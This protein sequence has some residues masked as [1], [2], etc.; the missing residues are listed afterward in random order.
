MPMPPRPSL[1]V[2]TGSRG[3]TGGFV[4]ALREAQLLADIAD[5]TL[6]VPQDSQFDDTATGGIRLLKLPFAQPRP[7]IGSVLGYPFRL[8]HAGWRLRRSMMVAGCK[9]LQINDF[10]FMEGAVARLFG[11]RGRIVTWVR[12]DPRRFGRIGALWLWLD[13]H[14]S[15][16][17]VAVSRHIQDAMPAKY[18]TRLIYDPSVERAASRRNPSAATILFPGNYTAGK[19]QDVAL[20]AFARL[21]QKFP[22]AKLVF[23]G[24]E[25]GLPKHAHYRE[26]LKSLAA[27]LGIA[28][29]VTFGD[30]LDDLA[31]QYASATVVLN[32]S[33]SE[34]FSLICQEAAA[35]GVPVIATRSGGPA[36]II[37]DGVTG[38]LVDVG[39]HDAVAD[40]LERLLA[41]SSLAGSM[42]AKARELVAARFGTA[43]FRNAMVELF[44]L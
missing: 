25:L 3:V 20:R 36:E 9:R 19:G 23:F 14:A 15:H 43:Q 11:F 13:H 17:I 37:E 33:T 18:P 7:T 22:N 40:R 6:V 42:G 35:H 2:F 12:I 27:D 30:F 44:D 26:S 21:L 34:S 41:D 29:S 28:A 10:S 24:G 8:L 31:P 32:L 4:A 5:V 16:E 39:D 38:F 1:F